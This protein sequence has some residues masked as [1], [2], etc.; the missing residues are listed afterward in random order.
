MIVVDLADDLLDDVRHRDDADGA[1]ILVDHHGQLHARFLHLLQELVD[2]LG[3]RHVRR[4]A[5]QALEVGRVRAAIQQV[6]GGDDA[7]DVDHAVG[8]HGNAGEAALLDDSDGVLRPGRL[9]QGHDVHQRHHDLAHGRVAEVEDLVD[10]LRLGGG[11]IGLLRLELEQE[12][13]LLP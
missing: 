10:H 12:L 9:R 3:L 5:H 11:H 6:H 13:Q 7:H 8:V 1:A 4:W 2:V